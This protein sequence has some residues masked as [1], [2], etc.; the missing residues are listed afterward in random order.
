MTKR[1][2]LFSGSDYYPEG[3]TG[4]FRGS[5]DTIEEAKACDGSWI[6]T[7]YSDREWPS[8]KEIVDSTDFSSVGYWDHTAARWNPGG[9][10]GWFK[11]RQEY[12]DA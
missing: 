3:G 9:L 2:L 6:P 8:W 7:G 4:D 1:Y 5:F 11:S 10:N 12:L